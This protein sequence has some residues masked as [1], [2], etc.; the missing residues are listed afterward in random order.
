MASGDFYFSTLEF[1]LPFK[2][3]STYLIFNELRDWYRL[4]CPGEWLN[5][6]YYG[7]LY[8]EWFKHGGGQKLEYN[9]H[10]ATR[11]LRITQL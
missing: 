1:M 4:W 3:L 11:V 10:V 5:D 7:F 2:I 9:M 6:D 8:T